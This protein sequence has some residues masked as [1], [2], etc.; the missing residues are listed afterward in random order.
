[1]IDIIFSS[2]KRKKLSQINILIVNMFL[3]G[4]FKVTSSVQELSYG[5]HYM[6]FFFKIAI[7]LLS[8]S[9]INADDQN[10]APSFI[11]IE[12]EFIDNAS[13]PGAIMFNPPEGWR[14]A[15]PKV[16][17]PSVKIMVV[18]KGHGDFP[19]SIN[20]G[21]ENYSGTLKEYLKIIKSINEDEGSEWKDLGTIR[22]QAGT[23][24]LSQ[25]DAKTEWGEIRMMH[26]IL[27]KDG[28]VYILTAAATKDEFG[29]FY[30]DFF[31]SMR[32]LRFNKDV[33]EM[34]ANTDKKQKFERECYKLKAG[35]KI[36]C[37][38]ENIESKLK[39][40]DAALKDVFFGVKFQ[41]QYWNPF[42]N[43]II[44]EFK[45]MGQ[46]WQKQ[47]LNQVQNELFSKIKLANEKA[48]QNVSY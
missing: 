43:M 29:R 24:S 16:L 11:S 18:G 31:K 17:P 6:K 26:V 10:S 47:V 27:L 13:E 36:V 1:M 34:I 37:N 19:P 15:D 42:K 21:I 4:E 46:A 41:E 22:T 20:L 7:Y 25:V 44:S 33:F 23:A 2:K 38:E 32:S 5:I 28:T 8:I 35:W 9:F 39:E 12:Q 40:S 14:L 48:V 3:K 30:K 45:D